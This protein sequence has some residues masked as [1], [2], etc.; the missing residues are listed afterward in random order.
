VPLAE[1]SI[2][3]GIVLLVIGFA[4]SHGSR[5]QAEIAF[6][7]ALVGFGALDVVIREHFAGYRSHT[8][9]L[10]G[11]GGLAAMVLTA[12]VTSVPRYIVV[13]IGASVF[14]FLWRLLRTAF[15]RRS[16]FGFRA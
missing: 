16:G 12:V 2:L 15:K 14:T 1:L 8:S 3:A 7:L 13:I 6:G 9:M 11:A 4:F 5:Q 10:A